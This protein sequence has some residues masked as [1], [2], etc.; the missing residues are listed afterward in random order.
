MGGTD[1]SL[2]GDISETF[3]CNLCLDFGEEQVWGWGG[4]CVTSC[5]LLMHGESCLDFLG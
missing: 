4:L 2:S 3:M 1:G 5:R